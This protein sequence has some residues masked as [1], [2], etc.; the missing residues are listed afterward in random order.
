MLWLS[1]VFIHRYM[2]IVIN[3]IPRINDVFFFG[4]HCFWWRR[5][6]GVE[7][8]DRGH[9][10]FFGEKLRLYLIL[11]PKNSSH[12]KINTYQSCCFFSFNYFL[13]NFIFLNLLS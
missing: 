13:N 11:S 8:M 1:W 5:F 12:E 4:L 9:P 2:D 7:H 3:L 10:P 6:E